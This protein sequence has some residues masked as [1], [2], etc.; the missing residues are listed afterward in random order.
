MDMNMSYWSGDMIFDTDVW[1]N[2]NY[3]QI[4]WSLESNIL[5][6]MQ[7]TFDTAFTIPV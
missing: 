3:E 1:Y 7:G 5:K 2:N 4:R 6:F